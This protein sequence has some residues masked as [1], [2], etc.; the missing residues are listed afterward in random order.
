MAISTPPTRPQQRVTK[1]QL[2]EAQNA[3]RQT[4]ADITRR[5]DSKIVE[6]AKTVRVQLK[7]V[8]T[9]KMRFLFWAFSNPS[10]TGHSHQCGVR[11]VR[12]PRQERVKDAAR[13]NVL[14]YCG[15]Q[16]WHW[17]GSDYWA[18]REAYLL[19]QQLSNGSFPQVRDP[20]RIKPV[21]KHLYAAS[22]KFLRFRI[23]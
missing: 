2:E 10:T 1:Q 21:C 17:W 3:V 22:N 16:F 19:G 20:N 8:D 23:R 15:C 13:L 7:R 14:M 5:I 18:K 11:F 6:R 9:E 4:F 12:G